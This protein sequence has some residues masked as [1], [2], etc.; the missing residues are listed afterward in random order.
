[1]KLWAVEGNTIRLDGGAMFGHV[2]KEIWKE[3]IPPDD[4]NRIRLACRSLLIETNEGKIILFEAGVGAF[5]EPKLKERYGIEPEGHLLL[6]N[7]ESLGVRDKDIDSV[8][9][10]HL[11]F[12]HAGG[13]LSPYGDG[14]PRLLFPH[15][16]FFVGRDHWERA[17]NPHV[18]EKM[19]FFP[20]IQQLLENSGR[21]ELIDRDQESHE[22]LDFGVFFRYSEGHTRGLM[23]PMIAHELGP[24]AFVSDLIPGIA[25]LHLPV[26]MG[27]DRFPE[28]IVDEKTKLLED[29][30][31]M[32]GK[33]FFTHDPNRACIS[34]QRGVQ[35]RYSALE[36]CF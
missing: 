34:L 36:A 14:D 31:G 8:V 33:V 28:L 15:A 32:G 18:R 22:E 35:G 4:L 29:V 24:I 19:S 5:F 6:K 9:L 16:R 11:H 13:L 17:R 2:P 3:W 25:W 26:T 27:Y 10:T 7:L 23:I 30:F 1:M 21:L 20:L 12:D